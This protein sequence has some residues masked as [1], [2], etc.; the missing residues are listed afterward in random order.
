MENKIALDLKKSLTKLINRR[1]KYIYKINQDIEKTRKELED[2]CIHN[3][4]EEKTENIEG[5]YLDRSRTITTV[6]CKICN[7]ELNRK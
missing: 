6:V 2:S 4:T 3:E 1:R 5:G 7:T